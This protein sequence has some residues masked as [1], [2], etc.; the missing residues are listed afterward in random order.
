MHWW[1][2]LKH[3]RKYFIAASGFYLVVVVLAMIQ[4]VIKYG[5]YQGYNPWV[6]ILY[7]LVAQLAFLLMLPMV[8]LAYQQAHRQRLR[9]YVWAP[10]ITFVA[11]LL[12]YLLSSSTIHIFGYYDGY[13]SEQYFRQY[14]G[15][16]VLFHLLLLGATAYYVYN[17]RA[18]SKVISGSIGR[19]KIEIQ[20]DQ[21]RWIEADDHYLKIHTDKF[22]MV[23]RSTLEQMAS[24]LRPDF[25]R[26]HRKYLVNKARITGKEKLKRDEYVVLTCGEKL[27][28]GRSYA[29]ITVA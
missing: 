15:R 27:K 12:F 17:L 22:A 9:Y 24:E 26:I 14:F 3:Q 7:L 4:N 23:K 13:L 2:F 20:I 29:P 18:Q 10:A 28:V 1:N 21:V 25:V 19:K 11:L 8:L 6:S 16:E 5:Q